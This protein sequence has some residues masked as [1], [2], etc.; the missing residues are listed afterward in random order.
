MPTQATLSYRIRKQISSLATLQAAVAAVILPVYELIEIGASLDT[1]TTTTI[2]SDIVKRELVFSLRPIFTAYDLD[3]PTGFPLTK[4]AGSVVSSSPNDTQGGTG[5]QRVIIRYVPVGGT[6]DNTQS[7]EVGLDGT[8]P[9]NVS[10]SFNAPANIHN[11]IT[12][13]ALNTGTLGTNAGLINLYTEP[14]AQA[15]KVFAQIEE[16]FQGSILSTSEVD[17]DGGTGARTV[18][19]TYDDV[20]GGGPHVEVVALNGQT[21]VNLVGTNH[22]TISDMT[23]TTAGSIGS[24]IGQITIYSGLNGTGGPVAKLAPSFFAYFPPP[25]SDIPPFV[26]LFAHILANKLNSKVIVDSVIIT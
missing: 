8:T 5:V 6:L 19:I 21:P 2:G 20:G 14:Q 4:F 1:D 15:G 17:V 24:N 23:I 26:Q 13:T 25:A 16:D 18:T 22:F 9:V 11:N 7:I 10:T 12:M 3:D